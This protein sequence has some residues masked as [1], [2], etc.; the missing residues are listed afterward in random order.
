MIRKHDQSFQF[1]AD[2]EREA[3]ILNNA[4]RYHRYWVVL[5]GNQYY[6]L[7]ERRL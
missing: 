4:D 2:A 6:I 7:Y 5:S 1:F 3:S